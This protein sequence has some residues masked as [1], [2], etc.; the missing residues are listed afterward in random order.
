MVQ[1]PE[2]A[3]SDDDFDVSQYEEGEPDPDMSFGVDA[4]EEVD[5]AP[6]GADEFVLG[7]HEIGSV[8]ALVCVKENLLVSV[9]D[10]KGIQLW[11]LA[12]EKM[13]HRIN[14]NRIIKCVVALSETV[15]ATGNDDGTIKT[16]DID[17]EVCARRHRQPPCS[18]PVDKL[19]DR[20]DSPCL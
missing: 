1:E 10:D 17:E 20:V 9:G 14:N 3:S 13:L 4:V 2:P 12:G 5:F 11:D 15:I 7:T 8:N 18:P 19:S 16:W 6:S